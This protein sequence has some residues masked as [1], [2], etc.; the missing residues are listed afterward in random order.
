VFVAVD[1]PNGVGKSSAIAALRPLLEAR[2][3]ACRWVRQPSDTQLGEFIRVGEQRYRGLTL[4]ALVVADRVLQVDSVIRPAL[5]GG[6]LVVTDRHIGSTLALQRID[7]VP[8]DVLWELNAGVLVP[9]LSVFLQAPAAV[10]DAR[11]NRRGRTSRFEH[12]EGGSYQ[13]ARFFQ[14]AA[15]LMERNGA[16]VL[17]LSTV[18][19]EAESVAVRIDQAIEALPSSP[20]V[21]ALQG[22]LVA[23]APSASRLRGR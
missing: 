13:E 22:Q 16:R 5:A 18:E 1:G 17:R 8:L 2:G 11:L 15:E 20:V 23:V 21:P 4:A 19:G 3:L 10:L 6:E 9:D 12:T 14:E 7:G